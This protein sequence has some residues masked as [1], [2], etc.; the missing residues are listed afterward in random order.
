MT[1]G[2][3]AGSGAL[4]ASSGGSQR[5]A[6][7]RAS[8]DFP[9]D[10]ASA[11]RARSFVGTVCRR[12]G[13]PGVVMDAEMVVTELVENAVRH[14]HSD[15]DVTVALD[16]DTLTIGV[17]DH[18]SAPPRLV[19]PMPDEP[20]GRGLLLVSSISRDWGFEPTDGGKLVWAELPI[21]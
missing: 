21:V 16:T 12:W 11:G 4:G 1:D 15:C 14:S 2:A 7:R 18:G 13:V 19:H 6:H 17:A 9:A 10:V 20:G 3:A 5:A 8:A